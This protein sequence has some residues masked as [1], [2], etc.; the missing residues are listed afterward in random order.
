[1]AHEARIMEYVRARGYPVPAVQEV[2]DDGL[3]LVMQRI[4]GLNM[5]DTLVKR[6][7]A[8]RHYGRL[9][10]DLHHSLHAL[11]T[12][13]WLPASAIGE[14]NRIVHLDL[15]PLNV[16]MSPTGPVVIDWT[17]ARRGDPA[18]DLALT[19][20]LL[21]AGSVSTNRVVG[22]VLGRA[23]RLLTDAF[24]G[25]VDAADLERSLRSVVTWK[26]HDPNMSAEE[27]AGMWRLVEAHGRDEITS[28]PTVGQDG[29]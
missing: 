15:H 28:I 26:V 17:N 25:S 8:V 16:I 18:T 1:M 13:E 21:E 2:S 7:W 10:A 6:P 4:D 24:L 19:W 12:P 29:N 20:V 27:Q 9:L 11:S 22:A 14:G 5:V 3:R 23:R